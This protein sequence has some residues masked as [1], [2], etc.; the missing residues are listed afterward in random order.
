M[1]KFWALRIDM[2]IARVEEVPAK[3]QDKVET[4]IVEN[5]H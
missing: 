1:A 5:L 3:L 4:Y 2:D